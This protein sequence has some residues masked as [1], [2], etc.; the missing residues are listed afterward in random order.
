M[1]KSVSKYKDCI[2]TREVVTS[3]GADWEERIAKGLPAGKTQEVVSVIRK[4]EGFNEVLINTDPLF[5]EAVE[6]TTPGN[7]EGR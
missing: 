4:H 3:C 7:K 1:S 5:K 2:V 6:Q